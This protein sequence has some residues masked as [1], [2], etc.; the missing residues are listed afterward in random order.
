MNER[1]PH[2]A[3]DKPFHRYAMTAL[4]IVGLFLGLAFLVHVSWNMFAP[5]L[6][7]LEPIR[8]K[9]ALG[10]VVFTGAFAAV[11]RFCGIRTRRLEAS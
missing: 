9:Q 7:H 6:F 8:M 3:G 2:A 1:T 10:L 4:K 5:D 11:V